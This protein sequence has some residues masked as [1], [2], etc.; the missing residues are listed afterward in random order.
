MLFVLLKFL[1]TH[2]NII[3]YK[4]NR[5]IVL[6]IAKFN[7]AELAINKN[8]LYLKI[9]FECVSRNISNTNN[10]IYLHPYC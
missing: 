1:G 7:N 10:I 2:S 4:Y 9:I 6:C 8:I 3:I 5:P